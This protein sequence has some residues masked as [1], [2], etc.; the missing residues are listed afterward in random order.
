M[1]AG[2]G[3]FKTHCIAMAMEAFIFTVSMHEVVLVPVRLREAPWMM[4]SLGA[5]QIAMCSKESPV[6]FSVH[7]KKWTE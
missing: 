7:E 3:G 6:P 1:L 2:G 5:A 4:C